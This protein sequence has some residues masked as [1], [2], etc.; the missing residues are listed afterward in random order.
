MPHFEQS[1]LLP[2][3]RERSF[4]WHES[5]GALERL[6]PPWEPVSV[7]SRTG[8]IGNGA[9]VVLKLKLGPVPLR[10]VAEHEGYDPPS[11]FE[12]RQL[13]GPF[14]AWHHRHLFSEFADGAVPNRSVLT[15]SIEYKLPLGWIG[16]LFGGS[17]ARKKLEAM[18]AYRHQVTHDDL[19]F[20][21]RTDQAPKR[22]VV[23]GASGLVGSTLCP[24]LSTGGH[25][26]AT[27]SRSE[28]TDE[29]E[30]QWDPAN[31]RLDP[32]VLAN[33][34]VVI[35]LAGES[36]VGRWTKEKK[37]RIRRSRIDSTRLIAETMAKMP[38]GPRTLVVASATGLYGDRGDEELNEQSQSAD[39]FLGSVCREW[40]A[41]ADAA[42]DAGIRVVHVRLGLVMSR[43]GGALANMLLPFQLGVGGPV[44]SGEQYWSWISLDDAASI[45]AWAA[46][47][48][49]VQGPVNATAPTP[50][51]SRQF[52]KVLGRVLRRPALLPLPK[53][54]VRAVFG[55]MGDTLL[56]SSTRVYPKATQDHGY[57]FRFDDLEETLRHELGKF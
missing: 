5:A 56:L 46:L 14:A 34:D 2:A 29:N 38:D 51:T 17:L 32:L 21:A 25:S 6:T 57:K 3:S 49:T 8:G 18:F 13:S 15:D 4:A 33:S 16:N 45:F 42:R 31:G 22:V 24:L 48:E 10:W 47:T 1:V 50:V 30:Y 40:E 53:I 27:L 41:S 54:A 28:P 37:E 9:Q 35:H 23:T 39:D 55:E 12:D 11:R 26:V 19:A 52:A 20:H 43:N 36:I 7:E 44:G